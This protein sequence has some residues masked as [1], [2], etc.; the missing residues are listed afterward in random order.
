[1]TYTVQ[2]GYSCDVFLDAHTP[3]KDKSYHTNECFY[4]KLEQV[5]KQFP[6]K[7]IKTLF[8]DFKLRR[9]GPS[10]YRK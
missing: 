9:Y 3:T 8:G 6:K 7:N 4:E 5:F 1:M 10:D 2:R